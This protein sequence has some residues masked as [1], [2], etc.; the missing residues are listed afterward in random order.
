MTEDRLKIGISACFLYPDP[1][2]TAF[3]KKTL[4]YVE[5]SVPHWVMSG[6][7]LP[8][9]IPSP[10]G[11]VT[12][13]KHFTG[14]PGVSLAD[15][16]QWLDGLVLHGGADLWPGT[17]QEEPIDAKWQGDAGRDKYEIA[18]VNA[19]VAAG[20]PVFGICRGMQLIN[21]AFGGTL[22]Q[23]IPTQRPQALRH[24]DA[25][26][27]DQNFHTVDLVPSTR[28]AALLAS[29]NAESAS[30]KIN[31]VHHQCVKDLAPNFVVEARCPDDGTVEAI[32]HSGAAWVAG[33]QWHPEFHRLEYGTLD[34][35]PILQDFLDAARA[36]RAA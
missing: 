27:Y 32:R 23:D 15:Y 16:A 1:A 30:H 7:A 13:K 4:Q 34:D 21:V 10:V 5:Q 31:S 11:E 19:F 6:G 28:L 9:M 36:S 26:V 18:L 3:A 2:R 14:E 35:A 20:K 8:V 29:T 33:V 24:R 25:D 17:Y 22:V 12:G